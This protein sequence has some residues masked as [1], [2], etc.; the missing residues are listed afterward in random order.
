MSLN[1]D[2]KCMHCD[3]KSIAFILAHT[4]CYIPTPHISTTAR[5]TINHRPRAAMDID[6]NLVLPITVGSFSACFILACIRGEYNRRNDMQKA[7]DA[8]MASATQG[9]QVQA[10]VVMSV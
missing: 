3:K 9:E 10:V 5:P 8:L 7:R 2:F 1:I 6:M 4:Q